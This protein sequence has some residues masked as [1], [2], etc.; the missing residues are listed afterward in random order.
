MK[1]A[2]KQLALFTYSEYEIGEQLL[3]LTGKTVPEPTRESIRI[4]EGVHIIDSYG[5]YLNHSCDPNAIIDGHKV[6]ASKWIAAG[7]EVT[8]DYRTTEVELACPFV[9]GCCGVKITG[10]N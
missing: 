7:A 9:C 2:S 6:M 4:A 5:S 10:R 1:T 3:A 8:F